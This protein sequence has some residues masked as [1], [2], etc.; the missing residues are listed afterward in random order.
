[1]C[2]QISILETVDGDKETLKIS[3]GITYFKSDF[4]KKDVLNELAVKTLI[5]PKD[6]EVIEEEAF[7]NCETL[8]TVIFE[9]EDII[10]C[11]N[12][13]LGC[14]NLKKVVLGES[15]YKAHCIQSIKYPYYTNHVMIA[16]DSPEVQVEEGC[17]VY[18]LREFY[19]TMNG[20]G[21]VGGCY[22]KLNEKGEEVMVSS[23]LSD[24]TM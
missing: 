23:Q 15:E 10:L 3:K 17:R 2:D 9:D 24:F 5:V 6:V 22:V 21:I 4:L 14:K 20:Q 19:P 8:E 11:R 7:K 13:F 16:V 12:A 1:M 18:E